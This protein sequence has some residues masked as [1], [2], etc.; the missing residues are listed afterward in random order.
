VKRALVGLS[1]AASM[2]APISRGLAQGT[3]ITPERKTCVDVSVFDVKP[4]R[5]EW[6][7]WVS[8]GASAPR[9]SASWR[10]AIGIGAELTRGILVYRG[11][12]A[13][14]GPWLGRGELRV[15]P[16]LAASTRGDGGVVEAGLKLHFGGVYAPRW[17]TFELRASGGEGRFAHARSPF[18][19]ASVLWG[20]RVVPGREQERGYCDRERAAANV[21][22]ASLLRI[23]S[24]Y[25]RSTRGTDAELSFGLELSPSWFL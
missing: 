3:S 5:T 17:G 13:S 8:T 1:I 19:G 20:L 21:A 4:A 9:N 15:G 18:V 22:L 16:W 23:F 12:P 7:Y 2:L 10:P 6:A 11:F 25:R 24:T 14:G